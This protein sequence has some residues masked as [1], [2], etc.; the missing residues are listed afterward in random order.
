VDVT[1]QLQDLGIQLSS[2]EVCELLHLQQVRVEKK[3]NRAV[4]PQGSR[5]KVWLVENLPTVG[6]VCGSSAITLDRMV[7]QCGLSS[8]PPAVQQWGHCTSQSP[9]SSPRSTMC[10]PPAAPRSAVRPRRVW[11]R[12]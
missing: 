5:L 9:A 2:L 6:P 8:W 10:S 7:S 3:N 4:S 12:P 11:C 1:L